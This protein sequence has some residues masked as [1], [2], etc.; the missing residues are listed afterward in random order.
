MKAKTILCIYIV[1][2]S[3]CKKGDPEI[4]INLESALSPISIEKVYVFEAGQDGY[5]YAYGTVTTV[6]N[7]ILFLSAVR[8]PKTLSDFREKA[9]IISMSSSDFGETWENT[10]V[11]QENIATK[12]TTSPS[13][14]AVGDSELLLTFSAVNSTSSIDLY[15]KKSVDNGTTWTD[16]RA[17]NEIGSGYHIAVNDRLVLSRGRLL[18]PVAFVNGDIFENYEKQE[19]VLFSS[20]NL[21]ESWQRSNVIK[22]NHSLMEPNI[23][24]V[25][26]QELLINMRTKKGY[27]YFARS[28]DAGITWKMEDSNIPSPAS[29][30]KIVKI[31]GTDLLV[32]VWNNTRENFR[33]SFN[34]RSPLSIAISEDKG[35]RW[36]YIADIEASKDFDYSYPSITFTNNEMLVLYYEREKI[37]NNKASLKLAKIPLNSLKKYKDAD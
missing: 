4:S 14:V 25:S 37:T 1:F 6:A 33:S 24:S 26:E 17:I 23:V 3:S 16:Y 34:N 28:T 29:P 8:Y 10:N 12:N 21:G 20:D 15:C 13:V 18:L 27:I 32:M 7:N 22:A 35:Y 2:L 30:Q 11:V 5:Q 19:I 9:E 36:R 31:P